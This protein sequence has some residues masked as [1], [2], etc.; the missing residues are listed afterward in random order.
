M[1]LS[2]TQEDHSYRCD[3]IRLPSVTQI[4]RDC[5]L[6]GNYNFLDPIHAFRGL[7]VHEGAHLIISGVTQYPTLEPLQPP[8][9]KMPDYVRVHGEIGGYW[10]AVRAAHAA[11]GFTGVIHECRL[12]DPR[13]G[14]AGT[15]DMGA[16]SRSEKEQLWDFKSG[17]MPIMTVVQ[18]CAYE[19][20]A[21][22]GE[23]IDPEHPGIE[24]LRNLVQAGQPFERCALRLEKTGRFTSY[25]ECHKGRS[26]SDPMWM[27][28]WKS[29]LYLHVHVPRHAY[30][31]SD[32]YGRPIKRSMLSN[33]KWVNE[34]IREN[35]R[36]P[37]LSRALR[38]G[39]NIFNV[40]EAYGLL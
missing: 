1:K 21:R 40:R 8:F 16:I 37:E 19:Q 29:A 5:G 3:G 28:V 11:I 25:F 32:Q 33:L 31:D 6:S 35:L 22:F 36:E 23:P 9:D 27:D 24:W 39:D 4:L 2:F 13:A 12:I 20:L 26:Y 30:V 15:F 14:Y 38:A 7:A 17:T 18:I 10:D 34:A